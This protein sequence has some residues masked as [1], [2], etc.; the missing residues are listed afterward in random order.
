MNVFSDIRGRRSVRKFLARDV[1]DEKIK[2]VLEAARWAPSWANTQCWR[3]ILVR[4]PERKRLLS[5]T[6]PTGNPARRS[7]AEAPV[8]LCVCGELG[9][10]GYYRGDVVTDKGD[11]YMF[12]LGLSTQ[13]ILLEAYEQGL[14][15]VVVGYFDSGKAEKILNVPNGFKLVC[16]I[17]MG[18]PERAPF[19]AP[20]R[21]KL[22]ELVFSEEW[23]KAWLAGKP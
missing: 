16:L 8:V 21:K 5:E 12:D 11:W 19:R 4:D 10:S 6:L 3:F 2:R 22:S 9:K 7:V 15:S 20:E 14:G 18:Y 1:E 17:P 13:N 23:G